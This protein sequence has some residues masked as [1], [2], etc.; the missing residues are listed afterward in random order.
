MFILP[1]KLPGDDA[2]LDTAH[3]RL[4]SQVNNPSVELVHHSHCTLAELERQATVFYKRPFY[5][6]GYC[7]RQW[8]CR[9]HRH[10]RIPVQL[11]HSSCKLSL[12]QTTVTSS[13]NVS[14]SPLAAMRDGDVGGD[15]KLPCLS[16]TPKVKK[17]WFS[18]PH[19][20]DM[21]DTSL[22]QSR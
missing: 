9:Y 1:Q 10:L 4:Q 19:E 2:I 6:N 15:H 18:G 20:K 3:M 17:S 8:P 5:N 16:G 13:C 7:R 14:S 11:H 22:I 21:A 12:V